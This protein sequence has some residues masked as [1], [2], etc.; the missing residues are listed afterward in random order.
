METEIAADD[1]LNPDIG[2]VSFEEY[3]TAWINERPGLRPK[4]LEVYSYLLR[5]HLV[6]T[7][8]TWALSEIREPSVRRWRKA[9]LDSGVGEVTLAKAYRLL[10]AIMSTAVD[11]G[12]IRR[13]PCRI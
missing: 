6:P 1:W 13:N 7:F 9:L 8:G 5:R 10:R 12:A 11:D 4:T 3:A 2:K